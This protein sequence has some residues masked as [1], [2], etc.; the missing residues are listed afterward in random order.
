MAEAGPTEISLEDLA[1]NSEVL[2][3]GHAPFRVDGVLLNIAAEDDDFRERSISDITRYIDTLRQFPKVKQI[4]MHYGHKLWL[5]ENQTGGQL[6]NY[7][8]QVDAIKKIAGFAADRDMEIVLENNR[9]PWEF[10]DADAAAGQAE[11][12]HRYFGD[13]PEEWIQICEDVN[14]PNVALCLD[15]SHACTYAHTFRDH[16]R[17]IDAVKAFLAKPHLI[18]HVHW[19]DNYMFDERGRKDSHELLGRGSLP[20]EVH[21]AIKGLDATILLEH[22]YGVEELEAELDWISRL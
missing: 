7:D 14:L 18:R 13:A 19:S 4:N 2:I 5:D 9:T 11:T 20:I 15:S 21:R 22:F 17:R 6:G 16:S 3:S 8:R 1:P 10:I 12:R